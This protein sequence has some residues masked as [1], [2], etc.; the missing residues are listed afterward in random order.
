[1]LNRICDVCPDETGLARSRAVADVVCSREEVRRGRTAAGPE[2]Y[3]CGE[4]LE[5]SEGN[6]H[7]DV[8]VDAKGVEDEG[9]FRSARRSC[10]ACDGTSGTS[11]SSLGD[12]LNLAKVVNRKICYRAVAYPL[13]HGDTGRLHLRLIF[14]RLS[15]CWCRFYRLP[16][17]STGT[18]NL[19]GPGVTNDV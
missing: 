12:M 15:Q 17:S 13:E 2:P 5:D 9:V 6:D 18:F 10:K 3:G 16:R 1:M 19:P 4:V 14:L 7:D 8:C 11:D